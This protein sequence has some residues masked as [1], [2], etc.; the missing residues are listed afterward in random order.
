[1]VSGLKKFFNYSV[2]SSS[3]F[4][5]MFIP[6]CSFSPYFKSKL[7]EDVVHVFQRVIVEDDVILSDDLLIED[8]QKTQD[9]K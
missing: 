5:I 4:L 2:L 6:K 1:M 8:P 3:G 9:E 7:D